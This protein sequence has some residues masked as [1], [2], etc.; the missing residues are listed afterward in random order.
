M[1]LNPSYGIGGYGSGLYGNEPIESLPIGYYLGLLTSQW[2]PPNSPKTNAF[3][4]F[5]LQKFDDAS[6]CL[7]SMDLAFDLD[8]AQGAQLDALGVIVGAKRT[9]GFQPSFAVSPILDD[10]TYRIYIKYKIVANQ[11]DGTIPGLYAAWRQIF[12]PGAP[13][14]SILVAD[15]Q[16]MSADV[17]VTGGSSSIL[18]DLVNNGYIVPRPE[19]VL[20][21]YGFGNLPVFGFDRND[22]YQAGFDLGKWS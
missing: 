7:V 15:Q 1:A 10:E 16:N 6:Q 5:L 22:A 21:N 3:L 13:P 11:W 14:L 20:Y 2:S 9:V 4:Q 8:F 17:I 19:G 12:L 18:T